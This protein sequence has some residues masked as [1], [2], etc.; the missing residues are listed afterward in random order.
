MHVLSMGLSVYWPAGAGY[1][2]LRTNPSPRPRPGGGVGCKRLFW[3]WC[4]SLM[5]DLPRPKLPVQSEGTLI[6]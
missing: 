1:I 2:A 5:V 6:A 3:D 4:I